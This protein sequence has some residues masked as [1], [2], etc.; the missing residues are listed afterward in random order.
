VTPQQRFTRLP[1]SDG[2]DDRSACVECRNLSGTICAIAKPGGVVS[3]RKGYQ[4]ALQD[5]VQRC[6]GFSGA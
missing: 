5:V 2:A 1:R 3:A 4:P 6:N